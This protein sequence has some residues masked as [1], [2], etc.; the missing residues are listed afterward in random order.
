M[1]LTGDVQMYRTGFHPAAGERTATRDWHRAGTEK[2]DIGMKF[3]N[4]AVLGK[5]LI[6]RVAKSK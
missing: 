1:S 6:F 3:I 2:T 5:L 4:P